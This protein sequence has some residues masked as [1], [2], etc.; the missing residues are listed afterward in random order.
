MASSGNISTAAAIRQP[1]SS[2]TGFS[3][4]DG[5]SKFRPRSGR[6][7]IRAASSCRVGIFRRRL[8]PEVEGTVS[9]RPKMLFYLS[10]D[11]QTLQRAPKTRG[12]SGAALLHQRANE[13]GCKWRSSRY[14]RRQR[15]PCCY[16]QGNPAHPLL[17]SQR[18]VGGAGGCKSRRYLSRRPA[19]EKRKKMP[20][21]R[22]R[23]EAEKQ[24]LQRPPTQSADRTTTSDRNKSIKTR[25]YGRRSQLKAGPKDE[26][27]ATPDVA[28]PKE[29]N[30]AVLNAKTPLK[31]IK[32]STSCT[33]HQPDPVGRL[34]HLHFVAKQKSPAHRIARPSI[35][36]IVGVT[37]DRESQSCDLPSAQRDIPAL[38]MNADDRARR[39]RQGFHLTS[40]RLAPT[41]SARRITTTL[42]TIVTSTLLQPKR[43]R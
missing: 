32:A 20:T 33:K 13:P 25:L 14:G 11:L 27:N 17:K 37:F 24:K 18:E 41:P 40:G 36:S 29:E 6:P 2:V 28:R 22:S 23:L 34:R 12:K 35:Q 10:P 15:R 39:H 19:P 5:H 3:P 38:A 7:A 30:R 26:K 1:P 43:N 21:E 31:P 9:A 8:P 4:F 16:P 42:T